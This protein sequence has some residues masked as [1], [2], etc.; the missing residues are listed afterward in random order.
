MRNY[1]QYIVLSVFLLFAVG[2]MQSCAK[3]K[4]ITYSSSTTTGK[5]N[6]KVK[7][8]NK[9]YKKKANKGGKMKKGKRLL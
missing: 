7:K 5:L 6:K 1:I 8:K 4:C 9:S 3:K 2:S